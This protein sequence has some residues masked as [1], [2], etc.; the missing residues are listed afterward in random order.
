ME[1]TGDKNWPDG[2]VSAN[3]DSCSMLEK[4]EALS[5]DLWFSI[6]TYLFLFVP[7]GTYCRSS[8]RARHLT[9]FCAVPFTSFYVT[10]VKGTGK[11]SKRTPV[12]KRDKRS[13]ILSLM[14]KFVPPF[15][16]APH[17]SNVAAC[18]QV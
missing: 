2:P 1:N 14:F 8:T 7:S 17:D 10:K 13:C 16:L 12:G 4:T 6:L 9:L 18:M 15:I 11:K 5:G 3:A